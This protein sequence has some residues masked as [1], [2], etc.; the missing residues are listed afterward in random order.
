MSLTA[1]A[2]DADTPRGNQERDGL[3]RQLAEANPESVIR[4][5][6]ETIA[7]LRAEG[8]LPLNHG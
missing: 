5:K 6:D 2:I 7:A 3:K 4:E 1:A 8:I